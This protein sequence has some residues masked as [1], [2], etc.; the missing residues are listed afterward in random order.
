MRKSFQ[1]QMEA[2]DEE[3]RRGLGRFVVAET[4]EEAALRQFRAGRQAEADARRMAE[5]V[6]AGDPEQI[7][8]LQLELQE[9]ALEQAADLSRDAADRATEEA[10]RN[11]QKQRDQQREAFEEQEADRE[12]AYQD[13]REQTLAMW[14]ER[15]DDQRTALEDDLE[16][17]RLWLEAKKKTFLEFLQ[18]LA[19][20]GFSVPDMSEWWNDDEAIERL[21][22]DLAEARDVLVRAGRGGGGIPLQRGGTIRAQRFAGRGDVVPAWLSH[23]ETVIDPRLTEKLEELAARGALGGGGGVHYHFAENAHFFGATP[24]EVARSLERLL[25]PERDRRVGFERI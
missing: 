9:R 12:Q 3:T 10:Q 6:A 18:F 15:R 4:P 7:R 22:P 19:R 24:R 17:W 1:T 5:A 8:D 14:Q 16:D 23:G 2:F 11:Y 20:A 21:W 13:E 25:K